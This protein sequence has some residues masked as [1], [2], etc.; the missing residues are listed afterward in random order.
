MASPTC[1]KCAICHFKDISLDGMFQHYKEE[2]EDMTMRFYMKQV[3]N[4]C[5]NY[6]VS[7]KQLHGKL[8]R[9]DKHNFTLHEDDNPSDRQD[10]ETQ[11]PI[12]NKIRFSSTPVKCNIETDKDVVVSRKK[13]EFND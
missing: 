8:I 12:N 2:H 10:L 6:G 13:I 3:K 4:F 5:L 9:F 7:P 11:S 1:T